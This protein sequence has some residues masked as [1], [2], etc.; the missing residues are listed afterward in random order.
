MNWWVVSLFR[1]I[2]T[3][4]VGPMNIVS[5]HPNTDFIFNHQKLTFFFVWLQLK[6]MSNPNN[7]IV[8]TVLKSVPWISSC[9]ST[10]LSHMMIFEGSI[11]SSIL[12][13]YVLY[14]IYKS[15]SY[16]VFTKVAKHLSISD[17][18][19]DSVIFRSF[20]LV[21]RALIGGFGGGG[22]YIWWFVFELGIRLLI[23]LWITDSPDTDDDLGNLDTID[24]SSIGSTFFRDI[25]IRH[26]L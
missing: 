5:C 6:A 22:G 10:F 18:L 8:N 7:C 4:A 17:V 19:P 24:W 13:F 2:R 1:N 11:G 9:R 12:E 15:L 14:T 3:S 21:V 23:F 26:P 16:L 25:L 20:S